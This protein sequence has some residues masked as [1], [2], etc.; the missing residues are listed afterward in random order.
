MAISFNEIPSNNRVPVFFV[1]FDTTRA[2]QGPTLQEYKVLL[3]GN[4]LAGGTKPAGQLDLVT[5]ESQAK[6]FYGAGSMLAKMAEA[7]LANNRVNS[8]TCIAVD[9][10]GAAVAADATLTITGP[11]TD[12]GTLSVKVAG[13]RYRVGVADADADTAIAAALVAEVNADPDRQV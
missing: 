3:I 2:Q 13:T 1:E 5:G 12:A 10:D 7:F 6:K 8:L 11:A 9:D 4:R